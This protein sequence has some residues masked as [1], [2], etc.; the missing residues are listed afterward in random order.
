MPHMGFFL[1]S[2]PFPQTNYFSIS[3][4][5]SHS[6]TSQSQVFFFCCETLSYCRFWF[7]QHSKQDKEWRN[8]SQESALKKSGLA[9]SS[10]LLC[11]LFFSAL[12]FQLS[13]PS[14]MRPIFWSPK[15]SI[16]LTFWILTKPETHALVV[17]FTSMRV[18]L[19][20]STMISSTTVSLWVQEPVSPTSH[21]CVLT[22]W[23]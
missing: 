16:Q 23:I 8:F 9:Y 19:A 4:L 5:L 3:S 12:I 2:F 14:T 18:F 21:V 10:P 7:A 22:L 20:D 1:F 11:A 17:T 6:H 13:G 15:M